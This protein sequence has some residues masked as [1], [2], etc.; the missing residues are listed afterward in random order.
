MKVAILTFHNSPN[1]AGAVLQAWA[2]QRKLDKL[3]H[4]TSI[5]DYHRKR[6]DRNNWWGFG[7]LGGLY[8]TLKRFPLEMIRQ[9]RCNLF[10][11]RNLNL[12]SAEYGER[13]QFRDADAFI[14]GSDQVFNPVH[15]E[16]NPDFLLDFVP[17]GK[18]RIAYG[19]SFGTDDFSVEYMRILRECL[20]RFNALSVREE[21]GAEI[22]KKIAGVESQVVLDPTLLLN[23]DE[24]KPLMADAV[25]AHVPTEPYVFVY[26]IGQHKDARRVAF[27]KARETGARR[28]VV[29]TN[30]RAEWYWPRKGLVRHV[31]IFTP[32]DFLA[33]VANAAYVVT[34]S[35]HGTA[36]SVI[37][38][39][40]FMSLLNCTAGDSRMVTLLNAK[41]NGT[42]EA[43]RTQSISFL[44]E[45]L[46]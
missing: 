14:A 5:I 17:P 26:L 7:S 15:N 40:N 32:A 31:N 34:N 2:L 9:S 30:A 13:V 20:P 29:M 10:R 3:G 33:Y 22:I 38:N 23:V 1:N 25:S 4:E 44:K 43:M 37:F 16:M 18:R 28:I 19:A 46:S 39:R 8:Y 21:T 24:Y 35:F 6:G 27:E 42:L 36:F 41:E 45:A 12:T 11:H